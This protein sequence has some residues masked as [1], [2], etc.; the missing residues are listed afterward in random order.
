ME[1]PY[2]VTL[3]KKAS[4]D[5]AELR[6]SGRGEKAE[7][8]LDALT[9]DPFSVRYEKLKGEAKGLYSVRIN[10]VD[11][12]VFEVEDTADEKYEGVVN[13]IRMRTH[14]KGI[15]SVFLL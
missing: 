7:A 14:Y 4:D 10:A 12:L 13:V 8:L 2:L 9:E 11:R 6:R 1:L 3:S 5:L 15:L